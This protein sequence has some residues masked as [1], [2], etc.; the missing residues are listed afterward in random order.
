MATVVNTPPAANDNASAFGYI[1]A[2]IVGIVLLLLLF[3]YGIPA[4]R[5]A[6]APA[7]QPAQ[8]SMPAESNN[9][10]GGVNIPDQIDVNVDTPQ[11]G[12]Q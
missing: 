11:D 6:G 4:M 12:N 2:A 3:V 10:N 8:Q 1:I 5:S 9:G 7:T